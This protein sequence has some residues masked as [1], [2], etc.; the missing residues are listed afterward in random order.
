MAMPSSTR[1]AKVVEAARLQRRYIPL[2]ARTGPRRSI[3]GKRVFT[4][5]VS[6]PP[7]SCEQRAP[8]SW[9]WLA[10]ILALGASRAFGQ[11]DQFGIKEDGRVGRMH[12]PRLEYFPR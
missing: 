1:H 6:A 12:S 5:E 4:P 9:R 3:A 7:W 8:L 10:L 2:T 11:S